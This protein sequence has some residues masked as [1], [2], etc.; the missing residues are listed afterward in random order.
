MDLS[1]IPQGE[2]RRHPWELA[3]AAFFEQVLAQAVPAGAP[4]R[5]LDAGSG[6]AFFS[7]ELLARLPAGSSVTCWDTSYTDA[8]LEILPRQRGPSMRFTRER[9]Q[10]PF[11][12]VLLMDVL[13]HVEDDRGFLRGIVSELLAP[14]GRVLV[15][16]PAWQPLYSQHDENLRHYRRY[17][18]KQIEAVITESGLQ[19]GEK[20]GAFHSLLLPRAAGVAAEKVQRALGRPAR[21]NA[22]LGEWKGPAWVS[23]LLEQ[24]LRLDNRASALFA[25]AGLDVPGLSWWAVCQKR[26]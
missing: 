23:S 3:R 7:G 19:L 21:A 6:D 5:V 18:P 9:P 16:V 14:G 15:T 25:R 2:F 8:Q 17:A 12:L 4:V 22:N 26:S 13:E 20:G 24:A 1:E 10:G 11:E